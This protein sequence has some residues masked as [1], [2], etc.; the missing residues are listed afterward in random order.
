MTSSPAQELLSAVTH[1][2]LARTAAC[3]SELFEDALHQ[4]RRRRWGMSVLVF[5]VHRLPFEGAELMERLDLDPLDI[6]HGRNERGDAFDVRRSS[7]KPGTNVKR[8]HTG[9]PIAASRSAKRK[10]GAK[11]RPVTER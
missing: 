3:R 5:K 11:S 6:L 10:V 1:P 2:H 7:V 4:I 8:T 9:L